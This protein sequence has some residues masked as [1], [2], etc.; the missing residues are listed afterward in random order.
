MNQ[1]PIATSAGDV[2]AA[3]PGTSS[4]K[5]PSCYA[6]LAQAAA[7][8]CQV[9]LGSVVIKDQGIAA[10]GTAAALLERVLLEHDPFDAPTHETDDV[11]EVPNIVLDRRFNHC[12]CATGPL[13]L[14]AYAGCALR[15]SKG[16]VLGRIGVY[17]TAARR[18]TPAQR[19]GLKTL[20]QQ[21]ALQLELHSRIAELEMVCGAPT[22]ARAAQSA[23]GAIN[24]LVTTAAPTDV[25]VLRALLDSAPVAIYRSDPTSVIGYVNR[26]YRRIFNLKPDQTVDDWALGVH[27]DDRARMEATWAAFC[28]DPRPSRFEYR[29]LGPDGQTRF[30]EELVVPIEGAPGFVGTIADFT[31]LVTARGDLRRA[32]SL[33]RNTF[34][35]A[36]LGIIYADRGGRLERVNAAF[37]ALLGVT[38]AELDGV[39]GTTITHAEDAPSS[40]V[41]LERLWNG[42]IDYIDCEKRYVRKDGSCVWVRTTTAL[43]REGGT[44]ER[45]VEYVRD[46]S[47]RKELAAAL[48]QQQTLLEAVISDLP[49][50]LLACDVH[51]NITHYNRAAVELECVQPYEPVD[52]EAT[53]SFARIADVYLIDGVTQLAADDL[54]LARALRGETISNLELVIAPAD[55]PRRTAL[56]S[57][58]RL[59]GPDGQTLGAVAVIQ[60]TTARKQQEIELER[61]HKELVTASRQAGMAEVATNVLHNV[62]NILNSVNISASLVAERL[63]QSK[64]QGIARLAALLIEQGPRLGQFMSEDERGK[65]IPEYLAALGEQ[66]LA[67][68]RVALEEIT[69]LREN[70]E[71]IKDTVAMQQSY[72]KRLGVTETVAV[73]DL[74][75]D[76]LR[77][78]AG[79]FT[80]HGVTLRREF[81]P[82]P[83]IHVDRHKVL[84]ILVNLIRNAKYACDDAGKAEKL[85]TLKIEPSERGVRIA[86]IDNGIGIEPEHMGRLFT[87]GFTT[88]QSGHGFGLHSGALAARE[89]GA[90]LHAESAGPGQGASFILDLPL[91]APAA[92]G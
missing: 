68:Q 58:R 77:L 23:S 50:A 56:S 33:H 25:D 85:I 69:A 5:L 65:R 48:L 32:E 13:A 35:Q 53:G 44:A 59:V 52:C 72:A 8:L 22:A 47:H 46:I 2:P 31:D 37:C 34:D 4:R 27:P 45:S 16:E 26:A 91:S 92:S 43:V 79:A 67:D 51:G 40:V 70:L 88:R 87:H 21:C 57:A 55:G 36:P 1:H 82:V 29:T 86:V 30:F 62:G 10:T 89:L 38:A 80:R 11:L 24:R 12:A 78:N 39:L 61:T 14:R 42:E 17:N 19:Q 90:T 6:S 7:T 9:P 81:T 49:V 66:L 84:Q 75:E 18:L 74:V 76:S 83:P 28:K 41:Q 3:D 63:R 71:H 15:T 54:P 64:A 73:V 20:A 60:D